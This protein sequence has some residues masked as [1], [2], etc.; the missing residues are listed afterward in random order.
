LSEY[1]I[2]DDSL[3]TEQDEWIRSDGARTFVGITDYAQSQLGDIVFVELPAVGSMINKDEPYGVIE[4][5]KAVSDL[6][7]PVTGEV[8]A[9]NEE[10]N[11]A[12]ERINEDCYGDGWLL[13]I[14]PTEDSEREALL[15]PSAYTKFLAER[16][17]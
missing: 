14:A 17:E 2:P 12:P 1:T 10:L 13:E 8:I 16:D 9:I 7:A 11:D 4:S 5:V 15:E 6:F 3:Y